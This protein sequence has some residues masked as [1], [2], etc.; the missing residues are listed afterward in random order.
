YAD[1][2]NDNIPDINI[3]RF[4][5]RT[6]SELSN[7]VQK[8]NDYTNKSYALTSVFA[9]DNFDSSTGYS[10]QNDAEF[11]IDTLPQN[12]K[13]NMGPNSKAFIDEDGLNGAKSKITN[14]INQ[15][16]ALTSFIGH[17]G[18]RDWSFSRVFSASDALLLAN[19][20]SPTLV[21][22][23]GC[24][25]TYFVSPEE[26]TMA[27]AFMLNQNGG[28]ASVLGASTLTKAEHEKDLAQLVLTYLTHD[29][30][31][32]G[33]AVTLAKQSYAIT[34]PDALDVILGWNILGDPGLKL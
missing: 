23:W 12:W 15:G 32:L 20:E 34:N 16:V 18:P 8:I 9:A 6:V 27:H 24:W 4:P 21:T 31:T 19:L 7:L 11:L 17:S 25:N 30:M 14:S 28:A 10:F 13:D 2:N 1:M 33:D 3:G 29:Q 22:Q 5:V 26:D